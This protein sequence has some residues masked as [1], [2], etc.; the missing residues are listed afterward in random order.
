MDSIYHHDADEIWEK[1]G[2]GRKDSLVRCLKR[3]YKQDVHW[4][5]VEKQIRGE[6]TAM[7]YFLSDDCVKLLLIRDKTRNTNRSN[8][9]L[10]IGDV[11][12]NYLTRYI[13]P[14]EETITFLMQVFGSRFRCI[15]EHEINVYRVDLFISDKNVVVECDEYGHKRYG[16]AEE[17]IRTAVITS[18]IPNIRWVRF[19]PHSPDFKLS[20]VVQK[21]MNIVF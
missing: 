10:Q 7:K 6:L 16:T 14:G 2:W 1:M 12:L 4:K 20:L 17:S 3:N 21:V 5:S 8:D 9:I 19:N 15:P 13:S 18:H 11:T